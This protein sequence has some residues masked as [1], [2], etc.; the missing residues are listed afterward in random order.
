MEKADSVP[1]VIIRGYVFEKGGG[2]ARE[3]IRSPEDDLFR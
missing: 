3:I 1:V 2:S